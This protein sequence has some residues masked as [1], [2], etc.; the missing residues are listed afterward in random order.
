MIRNLFAVVG[1]ATLVLAAVLVVRERPGLLPEVFTSGETDPAPGADPQD[2]SGRPS[3]GALGSARQKQNQMAR[4]SGPSYVVL[5]AGE[6]ASLIEDGLDDVARQ[7]LDS[8]VV[9]LDDGRFVMEAVLLTE[10]WG[11]AA[12]G[13]FAGMLESREPL[14]VA[15]PARVER[16]GVIAWEP[17]EFV[18][19]TLP[20]PQAAIPSMVNMLT[21]AKTGAI[22][23]V[24]PPTVGDVRI[25]RSGVTF[26]R[27]AG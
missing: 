9:T 26:Y 22:Y 2:G 11:R 13:P 17:D 18:L 15:G 6:I 25:R 8:I 27:R 16:A 19:R 5:S 21:G 23:L 3:P 24:V 12:L 10:I 7:A 4:A 14:R 20:F 1:F